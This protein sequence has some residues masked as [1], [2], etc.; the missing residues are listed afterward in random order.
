MDKLTGTITRTVDAVL[1]PLINN[2]KI[3]LNGKIP[4]LQ[5]NCIK[6]TTKN[7]LGAGSYGVAYEGLL[8]NETKV[9][10]KDLRHSLWSKLTEGF[11]HEANIMYQLNDIN[12]VKLHGVSSITII[13]SKTPCIVM[14]F[15]ENG[16]LWSY[17]RKN[18]TLQVPQLIDFSLQVASGMKY[19]EAKNIMHRDLATRNVLVGANNVLKISGFGLARM[20][21]GYYKTNSRISV[22]T[23]WSAPETLK[24]WSNYTIKC[25]VWSY[26]IVL[27]EIF[28]Y[29]KRPYSNI[30]RNT[31]VHKKVK[32]GYRIPK[33]ALTLVP[34]DIYHKMLECWN[35]E[36]TA[37]PSAQTLF[38]YFSQRK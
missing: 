19:L 37:R 22:K 35:I 11:I 24:P 5:S 31:D 28:T 4:H 15:L 6:R 27:A 21:N 30:K 1:A 36:P 18:E 34:D 17:L 8:G 13:E 32:N 3:P 25:D 23:R 9:A 29:G 7:R 33:T 38:D 16:S 20:T 10:L 26:G 14:E 12:I 2:K